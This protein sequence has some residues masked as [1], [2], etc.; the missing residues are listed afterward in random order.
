MSKEPEMQR[1]G[2]GAALAAML[3][4][5]GAGSADAARYRY[6]GYSGGG[7]ESGVV[8]T[9][10]GGLFNV[11]NADHVYAT[12]E[13]LQVFGGGLNEV[14]T[15]IPA[16]ED[17]FGGRFGVGY[18]WANGNRLTASIESFS[19]ET[20]AA[21]DGPLNGA[22]HYAIGPPIA[23]GG[24]SFA[25]DS[26]S[27]G[28]FDLTT[29]TDL[30]TVDLTFGR[31]H[32][33]GDEFFMEW[34]AGVRYATYEETTGG[35][36]D[37]SVSNSSAFGDNRYTVD[38]SLEGDMIG[39][40]I[41][42]RGNYFLSTSF[43][44]SAG[45]G[46]SFLDGEIVGSSGLTPSGLVNSSTQPASV[47]TVDDDGRS[48][49]TA[50]IDVRVT[51]HGTG[52]RV[53]VWFGWEQQDWDGIADDPLRNFPGTAAPLDSRDSIVLSGYRVGASYRF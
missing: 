40:R 44:L 17:D 38:K 6:G 25:G 7:Q 5:L 52:D 15:L 11:R 19:T 48:G 43:S 16:S 53:R 42:A 23:L 12:S 26:G 18:Q 45:I 49:K 13:S 39:A 24:G 22:L 2:T 37:D 10:E 31:E 50:E 33:L 3:L 46:L 28:S 35:F 4:I 21:A 14:T 29:E 51:W 36:Y 41:A 30:T 34:S 32:E 1:F 47:S 8:I 27:P 20:S 9:V